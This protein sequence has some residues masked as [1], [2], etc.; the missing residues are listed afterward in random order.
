MPSTR[1]GLIPIPVDVGN[2]RVVN[3]GTAS[4]SHYPGRAEDPDALSG[5]LRLACRSNPQE[6][7]FFSAAGHLNSSREAFAVPTIPQRGLLNSGAAASF[8]P[9]RI[10]VASFPSGLLLL[11][12]NLDSG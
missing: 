2:Q 12:S 8:T 1:S 4:L 10:L 3:S 5:R 11:L 9:L 6:F 7:Y